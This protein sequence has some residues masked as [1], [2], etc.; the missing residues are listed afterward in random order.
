MPDK[1]LSNQVG[2]KVPPETYSYEVIDG[3]KIRFGN[4]NP[5]SHY[6]RKTDSDEEAGKLRK[7]FIVEPGLGRLLGYGISQSPESV[8]LLL[9]WRNCRI[10]MPDCTME[11]IGRATTRNV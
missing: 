10:R 4:H 1:R 11:P 3:E 6:L 2:R 7:V 8:G 5:S 9:H